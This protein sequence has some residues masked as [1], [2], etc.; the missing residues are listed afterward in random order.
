MRVILTDDPNDR[1]EQLN[2]A[3]VDC[4]CDC[5]CACPVD[6][7]SSDEASSQGEPTPVLSRPVAYYLELTPACQNRCPGCGNVYAGFIIRRK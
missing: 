5:D 4:A 6:S 2:A 3:Q 7:L 1:G